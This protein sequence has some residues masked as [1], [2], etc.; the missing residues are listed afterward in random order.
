M[1]GKDS[2]Q[3]Y[4]FDFYLRFRRVSDDRGFIFSDPQSCQS[5]DS[6]ALRTDFS[7]QPLV[8]AFCGKFLVILKGNGQRITSLD[9]IAARSL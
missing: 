3:R 8:G 6:L 5:Q 4:R 1:T 7:L 2:S 9:L